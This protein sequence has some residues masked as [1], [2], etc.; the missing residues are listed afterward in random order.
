MGSKIKTEIKKYASV[1]SYCGITFTNKNQKTL[2]HC[3]PKS[4]G[5][6]RTLGNIVVCCTK[7]NGLKANIPFH[8]WIRD[9]KIKAALM[10]YLIYMEGFKKDYTK[11]IFEKIKKAEKC[12]Q[13]I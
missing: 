6:K 8:V 1:C 13:M 3:K 9:Y 11:L 2:D 5:G 7:C 4:K 10:R 12:H